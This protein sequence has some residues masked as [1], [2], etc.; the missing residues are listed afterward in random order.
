MR[1]LYVTDRQVDDYLLKS[2]RQASHVV[3]PTI[4]PADGAEMVA[5]GGLYDG[6]I[7]D[8]SVLSA[9][10][11]SEFAKAAHEALIM[12]IAEPG[13][14]AARTAVLRA[15]ADACFVRPASFIELENRLQALARLV[16]RG[17]NAAP[18][19]VELLAGQR[20]LRVNNQ[21][22]ALSPQE[23]Q[24][25]QHLVA[26]AGEVVALE[27]LRQQVW[28]DEAETGPELVRTSISRL[29]RKLATAQAGGLLRA[30]KGHGYVLDPS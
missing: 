18:T 9:E 17:D 14:E 16:R 21:T 20:S 4:C 11:A 26:H 12:M 27:R 30:V 15:G 23:Y 6:V 28:G 13:D 10:I 25:A 29:R 7:L 19:A 22:I 2:L 1:L 24:I 3:E 5:A 8:W